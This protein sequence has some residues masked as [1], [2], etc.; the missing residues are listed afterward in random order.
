MTKNQ[1]IYI[2]NEINEDAVIDFIDEYNKCNIYEPITIYINS[3]GGYVSHAAVI[4]DII[5]S[6]LNV[7]FIAVGE[8]FSAAFNLFFFSKCKN[9]IILP[10]TIGMIH[11][12]WSTFNLDETGKPSSDYDKFIITDMKANKNKTLEKLQTLG[13]N[14]KEL[15]KVKNSKDCYFTTERLKELLNN[16]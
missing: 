3:P 14:T 2:T 4:Q 16:G 1:I 11:F 10:E 9:K 7:T 12:C 8:I 15:T 13:L 6:S 5:D